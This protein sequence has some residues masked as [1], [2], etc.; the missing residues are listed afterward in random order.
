MRICVSLQHTL[1]QYSSTTDALAVRGTRQTRV[2]KRERERDWERDWERERERL[3][4][5]CD[6]CFNAFFIFFLFFIH[7]LEKFRVG[8]TRERRE[9]H[10]P[11]PTLQCTHTH[12]AGTHAR[13]INTM[14][15]YGFGLFWQPT[16]RL[17]VAYN[18]SSN[19]NNKY[20]YY[21]CY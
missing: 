3:K 7:M 12:T 21:Y 9:I 17:A 18:N 13:H 19:N 1:N 6:G 14:V 16:D 8:K 20:Y 5:P 2:S 15:Y 4:K 10:R 11:S